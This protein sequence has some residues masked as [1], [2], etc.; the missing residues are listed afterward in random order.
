MGRGLQLLLEVLV[1]VKFSR[2]HR[3]LDSGTVAENVVAHLTG[4][5]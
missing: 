4:V 5:T 1:S 3:P 2:G